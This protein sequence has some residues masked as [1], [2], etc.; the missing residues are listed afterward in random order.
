MFL[1]KMTDLHFVNI[2][3][4]NDSFIDSVFWTVNLFKNRNRNFPGDSVVKILY[5]QCRGNG[6][7]AKKQ[8]LVSLSFI[9]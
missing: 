4:I 3:K 7:V 1:I 5:F 6:F 8:K 9:I 2:K